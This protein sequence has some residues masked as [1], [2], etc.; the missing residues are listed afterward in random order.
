MQ[1]VLVVED[2]PYFSGILVEVLKAEGFKVLLR[3]R[4]DSALVAARHKDLSLLL[5]DQELPD[6]SGLELIK[7]L[8]RDERGP[9]VPVILMST[10]HGRE[11][12]HLRR[13]LASLNIALLLPKPF[14]VLDLPA[15]IHAVL[16]AAAGEAMGDAL[17][18]E[19]APTEERP[20]ASGLAL[21]GAPFEESTGELAVDPY[22]FEATTDD[23]FQFDAEPD[24]DPDEDPDDVPTDPTGA[25]ELPDVDD[26]PSEPAFTPPTHLKERKDPWHFEPP[27][28]A[29]PNLLSLQLVS[30]IWAQQKDGILRIQG[31][32]A[33]LTFANGEPMDR[34]DAMLAEGAL[35]RPGTSFTPMEQAIS[36]GGAITIAHGLLEA[37]RRCSSAAAVANSLDRS[38]LTR[39]AGNA[40]YR[41]PI[42]PSV[43]G[44]LFD[45][46]QR[47]TLRELLH[48]SGTELEYITR[49][50]GA[51]LAMNLIQLGPFKRPKHQP[52]E[53]KHQPKAP[54]PHKIPAANPSRPTGSSVS[55][56]VR[57]LRS[58]LDSHS[59]RSTDRN[60]PR[61]LKDPPVHIE[62]IMEAP[63]LS[64]PSSTIRSAAPSGMHNAKLAEAIRRREADAAVNRLRK[65]ME[66]LDG[67]SDWTVLSLAPNSD[68]DRIDMA[69]ER[70]IKRYTD[71]AQDLTMP[72][73]GRRDAL[74]LLA[75]VKESLARVSSGRAREAVDPNAGK[76]DAQLLHEQGERAADNNNWDRAVQC[77][78]AA[79]KLELNSPPTIAWLGWSVY[80]QGK[81]DGY[82]DEALEL[83]QVAD[84]FDPEMT[85]GQFFLA[86][87]EANSELQ[88]QAHERLARLLA[89]EPEH[90]RAQALFDKLERVLMVDSSDNG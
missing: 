19:D 64:D 80:K 5:I 29:R 62:T 41:L 45:A 54:R 23:A 26:P 39:S 36:N 74:R 83:L 40:V 86:V 56:P 67:V 13:S 58:T 16:G 31:E 1:Q 57:D 75:L 33:W 17:P 79:S 68:R 84:T 60:R 2:D 71:A 49:D 27:E 35:Y 8:R 11:G 34:R 4:A 44:L 90:E 30:E 6:R 47:R 9:P 50:L 32:S 51:L 43:A 15:K 3:D 18:T 10:T 72:D 88:E 55:S 89:R 78:T 28:G 59:V 48:A 77:F 66:R 69:G 22:A 24:V 63:G 14:T 25:S 61:R 38:L 85:D 81:Q 65:E 53:Q 52:L 37:G 21:I 76:S 46:D 12:E 20:G 87:V 73:A 82:K 42:D 70:M 7:E